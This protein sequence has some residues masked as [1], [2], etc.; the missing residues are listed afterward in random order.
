MNGSPKCLSPKRRLLETTLLDLGNCERESHLSSKN[1]YSF[2]T[3]RDGAPLV[4]SFLL[5]LCLPTLILPNLVDGITVDKGLK[6][7]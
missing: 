2:G 5:G 4:S 1:S 6:R 7:E 3:L